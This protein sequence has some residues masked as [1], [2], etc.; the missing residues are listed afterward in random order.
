MNV[1]AAPHALPTVIINGSSTVNMIV[2][3][4]YNEEGATATDDMGNVL[5][6]TTTGSV[7]VNT[8][9]Q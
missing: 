8:I 5:G 7:D 2:G 9:G 1:N 3:G 4:T 6:V